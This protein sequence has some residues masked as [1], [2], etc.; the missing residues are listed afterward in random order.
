MLH[1]VAPA[2]LSV[3]ARSRAASTRSHAGASAPLALR[4][5][6]VAGTAAPLLPR[7]RS[8]VVAAVRSDEPGEPA[9][10]PAKAE[11]ALDDEPPWVRRERE[12]E[13]QAG[14]PQDLPFGVYLLMSVIVAIAAVRLARSRRQ[15][16]AS[17]AAR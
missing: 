13:L 16:Y 10:K 7:R 15:P 11:P 3:T 14:A 12:R 1:A 2:R 6:S 17:R 4:H 5:A 8:C 9:P